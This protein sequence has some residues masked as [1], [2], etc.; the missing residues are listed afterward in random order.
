VN[1][2]SQDATISQAPTEPTF[3]LAPGS[4]VYN[5]PVTNVPIAFVGRELTIEGDFLDAASITGVKVTVTEKSR[6]AKDLE[7]IAAEFT[8]LG[9]TL[10][11]Q[12]NGRVIKNLP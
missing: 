9:M 12:L 1:L 8:D 3:Y 6:F 11:G 2:E 10:K 4:L 5:V 7:V